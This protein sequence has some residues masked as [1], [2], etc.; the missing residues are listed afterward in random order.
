M[1]HWRAHGHAGAKRCA[2]A[3]FSRVETAERMNQRSK[4]DTAAAR[5]ETW[6]RFEATRSAREQ[7]KAATADAAEAKEPR[8]RKTTARLSADEA[9]EVERTKPARNPPLLLTLPH[10]AAPPLHEDWTLVPGSRTS[11][12]AFER[13]LRLRD[14]RNRMIQ[15]LGAE[16]VALGAVW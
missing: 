13:E 3:S 1:Q 9:A 4:E 5:R 8:K 14:V 2:S 10:E 16:Y 7:A 11:I 6:A 12:E 15:E